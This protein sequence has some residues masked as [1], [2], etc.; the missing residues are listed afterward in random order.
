MCREG[1]SPPPL[2]RDCSLEGQSPGILSLTSTGRKLGRADLHCAAL[3]RGE[4]TGADASAVRPGYS[5][6]RAGRHLVFF[7]ASQNGSIA[8]VRVLHG[9]MDFPRRSESDEPTPI[10]FGGGNPPTAAAWVDMLHRSM[11]YRGL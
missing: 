4:A 5:R 8:I 9:R 3:A 11:S 1:Q 10:Y 6:I 2:A 7:P